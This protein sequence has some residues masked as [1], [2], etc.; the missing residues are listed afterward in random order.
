MDIRIKTA[1]YQMTPEVS[2]YLDERI[3][4]IAKMLGGDATLA[5]CEVEL[6]RAAGNQQHG[7]NM[8]RAEINIIYPGGAHIRATNN[9]E[10]MNMAIEDAKE[11]A[12]RQLRSEKQIHRRYIRKGGAAL[13]RLMRLGE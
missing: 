5:R 7:N 2:A 4:Y 12:V 13:K 8:W 3:A 11:E 10:N 6:G 1:D 9:A